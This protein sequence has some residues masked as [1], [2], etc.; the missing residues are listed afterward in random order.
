MKRTLT[1]ITWLIAAWLTASVGFAA[2]PITVYPQN[3]TLATGS[4]LQCTAYVP[5]SPNT[6][7]WLV[8]GIVGGNTN[9]GTISQA[10]LYTSPTVVPAP[11]VV[12]LGA[13]STAYTNTIGTTPLTITRPYPSLWSVSPS[14]LQQGNY[15]VS[16][17]GAN[18]TPDSVATANGADVATT[19]ISP[20][21][22]IAKG[23]GAVGTIKFAVRVPGNGGLT[24]NVVSV[25][26]VASIVT[27]KVN[28]A[29]A[30]VPLGGNRAF[31]ANVAGNANTAVTWAVNGID[32]G[33]TAV[34]L[35][36]P[37]G[38]YT[39]PTVLPASSTVTVKA[40]SVASPASSGQAVVTL[41]VPPP[42]PVIV[43][44]YPASASVQ[45]GK[46]QSFTAT[47]QNSTNSAVIWSVNGVNGGSAANGTIDASG[48]YTAPAGPPAVAIVVQAASVASPASVGKASVTLNAPPPPQVWLAGARFLEQSSFGPSPAS[49]N[50]ISQVGIDAYLA[51]QFALPETPIYVPLDNNMGELQQ[52]VL[53]NY[54]TAPDQLRQRL[55][56][57]LSGLLVTSDSKLIYADEIIP[58]LK[59]MSK[60]AFGNYRSLLRDLTLCPSMAKYLD[61]ANSMKPGM[62]GGANENYARELMQLFTIGLWQ[63]NQDGSQALDPVTLQ[64]IPTYNQFTVQQMA[65]ALTGWTYATAPGATPQS[66]NWEYFG[67]PLEPRPANHATNS[68]TILNC[69]LPAGQTPDQDLDA[70]LDCLMHHAN[71]AP[72]IAT[73]L[74]RSLVTSNPSPGYIKRVADV[75]VDNGSGV[76]GDLKAVVTAILMDTEARDDNP[77]P[78]GGRLKEP[79]L[80]ISAFLR[81]LGGGY[82]TTEGVT[83]MYDEFAQV[84]L[85]PP[86][87][88]SWYSPAYHVPKS[89][90]F[91]PEF[92]IYTPSQA[93]LRGNFF[94]DVLTQPGT[95]MTINL[96]PFQAYGNDMNGLVELANQTFLY[97]RMDPAM[98]TIIATAAAP[99]YDATTRI[100]TAIY[101]TVLSG[102]YAVQ[103]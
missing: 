34:G 30:S 100:A 51:Q 99:G 39:A 55:A 63:L 73:R 18:F 37:A 10:G 26:V 84:P 44:V 93:T 24:G 16:F 29:S 60:Y 35:I 97:G 42:P 4:T 56:Y 58:W 47:V 77:T 11:N 61:L 31:V 64:P 89:P 66:A 98:K 13:R 79:I 25:T 90:L 20:T 43:S 87:V 33:S 57:A 67:A 27:V 1:N 71:M 78:N 59:L 81:A 23:M 3:S 103:Y 49:L 76:R 8:N 68:K 5:L 28:P 7:Q 80:Q 14:P 62:A 91:G 9:I 95:D 50:Q 53:Y 82:S 102:Q 96:A 12:T 85:G 92:Q 19:Y 52:W 15:Q 40:T 65:L 94:Y 88:F 17:N 83:Y 74:I 70:V 32:G 38:L 54:T 86:S 22:L 75:F 69:V 41:T 6:I 21:A 2:N 46:T 72:F 36:S 101:L 45:V 48:L